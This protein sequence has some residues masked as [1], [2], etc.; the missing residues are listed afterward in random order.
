MSVAENRLTSTAISEA[1]YIPAIEVT[2]R[3]WVIEA[4]GEIVAFGVADAARAN[5]WALFVDPAHEQSGYGRR[6]HDTMVAWLWSQGVDRL[7]LTTSADTR[8]ERFYTA[9][10]WQLT[11]RTEE[12]ELVFELRP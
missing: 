1:D 5:I 3:G 7:W 12:G 8:A 6:L 11:G 10:G 2:G 9:A 4:Q